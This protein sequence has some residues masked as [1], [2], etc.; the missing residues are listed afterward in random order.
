MSGKRKELI[1]GVVAVFSLIIGMGLVSYAAFSYSKRGEKVNTIT[2]GTI[3]MSYTES[4]NIITI[5]NALPTTDATGKIRL[6]K[7]EYFD[8]SVT[9][10]ITGDTTID[11]EIAAE[12]L[13]DS[14]FSGSNIKYYLTKLEGSTETEVLAPKIYTE[15]SSA[16]DATGRPVH[17]MSLATGSSNSTMTTNYRLRLWVNESYNPQGDGG[18]LVYK[19]RINVYGKAGATTKKEVSYM[20]VYGENSFEDFH[21]PTIKNR[22]VRLVTTTTTMIPDTALAS[23]DISE[24]GDNSV[25]AYTEPV[26][27]DPRSYQITLGGNGKVYAN[28][29][30]SYLFANFNF[31]SMDLSHLDT[32]YVTNMKGMFSYCGAEGMTSLDLS[33]FDT[34]KV[35][36]MSSMFQGNTKY[37]SL[38]ISSFNTANV[39]NM[40]S[41]FQGMYALTTLN[42]SNFNTSKVTNMASM[43]YSCGQLTNLDISSFNTAKVTTFEKMFYGCSRLTNLNVV[44]FNT[45]SATNMTQM[46]QNCNSIKELTLGSGWTNILEGTFYYIPNGTKLT[47]IGSC[48]S[49]K[50]LTG[51]NDSSLTIIWQDEPAGCPI[52]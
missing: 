18:G 6:T 26:D 34:S 30:A 2:T 23:F 42:L 52:A 9:T 47:V 1:I 27:G 24:A 46:F 13:S 45:G 43:F 22:A 15:E 12:D 4:D 7:G 3:Q 16:N 8:F 19:T 28:P 39:T 50:D 51:L 44:D 14:T 36:D 32:S 48:A 40:Q 38:N 25:V 33:S 5:T 20:K 37:V 10:T 17:M 49:K 21:N 11:W 29:D 35:T 41:M 31:T